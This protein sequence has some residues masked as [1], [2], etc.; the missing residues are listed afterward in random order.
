MLSQ[1][2]SDKVLA[3]AAESFALAVSQHPVTW[4]WLCHRSCA[5]CCAKGQCQFLA[6]CL[7]LSPPRAQPVADTAAAHQATCTECAPQ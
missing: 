4:L 3:L 1:S 5:L 7:G 6:S 2:V